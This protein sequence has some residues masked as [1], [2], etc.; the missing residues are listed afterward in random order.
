MDLNQTP[1][2][3]LR[4]AYL[5]LHRHAQSLFEPLGLTADQYV[6]MRLLTEEKKQMQQDLVRATASDPS[7]VAAM[8][9]L[10]EKRG[11]VK[12]KTNP[13]DRRAWHVSLTANGSRLLAAA[14]KLDA[15]IHQ[16]LGEAIDAE[17]MK[18]VVEALRI[19]TELPAFNTR[20]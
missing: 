3:H 10:L 11:L 12:R 4:R 8:V 13:E 7:T 6:L 18:Q 14:S 17:R 2:M 1:A 16:S 19:I 20:K 9:K 5:T 15:T